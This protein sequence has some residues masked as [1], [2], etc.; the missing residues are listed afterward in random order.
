MNP[1]SRLAALG[2]SVWVDGLVAAGRARAPRARDS[3]TGLTSNPTIFRAAVLARHATSTASPRSPVTP[4]ALRTARD[5]GRPRRRRRARTR[6]ARTA[7][8]RLREPRGRAG[9]GR[10]RRR[11][12]RRRARAMGA[13]GPAQRD[14]QDP[15]HARGGGG[16]APRDRRRHQRQRH[17]AVLP[18]ALRGGDRRVPGRPRASGGAAAGRSTTSRRSPAS[19]SRASTPPSTA[20]W[21]RA[22]ATTSP[23][24]PGSRTPGSRT[25]APTQLF[26]GERFAALRAAGARPQ[27]LLWASTATKDPRYSDVKYVDELAGP[28]RVNTMPP[29]TLAAFRDHGGRRRPA[30]RRRRG[31]ARRARRRRHRPRR[32]H[33]AARGGSRRLR[34]LHGRPARGPA[35]QDRFRYSRTASTRRWS[36]G[37][38]PEPEL[39]EDAGHVALHGGDGH[40]QLGRDAAVGAALGHQRHHLALAR[41]E[42]VERAVSRAGGRPCAG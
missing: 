37:A 13:R 8:G 16:D 24:A 17:A 23:A 18:R 36:S 2:T 12:R 31:R 35:R 5:R 42:L 15:R 19:S 3:V 38:L 9:A 21:P 14:D 40:D 32:R 22:A 41:R 26:G 11:H 39:V 7:E 30:P 20:C 25:R 27:R 34:G 6:F 33:H 4:A 10:G 29:A 28:R 1:L